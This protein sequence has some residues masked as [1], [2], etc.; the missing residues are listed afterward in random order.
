M[1][2]AN[3]YTGKALR[4]KFIP[5][6]VLNVKAERSQGKIKDVDQFFHVE[7]VLLR[8]RTAY[9]IFCYENFNRVSQME[10]MKFKGASKL[11][12][13]LWQNAKKSGD[14]E[15]YQVQAQFEK[16]TW[17]RLKNGGETP[18][19]YKCIVVE[20]SSSHLTPTK[21]LKKPRTAYNYYCAERMDELLNDE[22]SRMIGLGKVLGKGW[23]SLSDEE[24][25]VYDEMAKEGRKEFY[26][27]HGFN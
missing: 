8:P 20:K 2:F 19:I 21:D 9:N 11:L 25:S 10:G 16:N 5:E 15:K 14:D 7:K 22:A 27:V 18:G 23:R 4:N 1:V 3:T 12:G 17:K 24:K 13:K 26:E 6:L